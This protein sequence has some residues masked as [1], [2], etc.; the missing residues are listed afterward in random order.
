MKQLELWERMGGRLDMNH[1]QYRLFQLQAMA[2]KKL[3]MAH[4]LTAVHSCE[5]VGKAA[6]HPFSLHVL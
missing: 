4:A 1:P 2:Q 5:G 3:G 6:C